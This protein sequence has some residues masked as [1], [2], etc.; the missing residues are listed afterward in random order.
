MARGFVG[1]PEP[2]TTREADVESKERMVVDPAS[3]HVTAPRPGRRGRRQT[4]MTAST[5][6]ENL[7]VSLVTYSTKY[8]NQPLLW[9]AKLAMPCHH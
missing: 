2:M 3:V 5:C 4:M 6:E 9:G 1:E 7:V 8:R